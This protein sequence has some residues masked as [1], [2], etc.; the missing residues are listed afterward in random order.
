MLGC[1][2]TV[3]RRIEVVDKDPLRT[4]T[5]DLIIASA[6]SKKPCTLG[7]LLGVRGRFLDDIAA[8]PTMLRMVTDCH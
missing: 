2:H 4:H 7:P 6:Q 3:I 8:A 1:F 5:V